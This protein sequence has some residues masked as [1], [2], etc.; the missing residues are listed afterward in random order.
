MYNCSN[1]HIVFVI[2]LDY[3][4]VRIYFYS[5]LTIQTGEHD[6]DAEKRK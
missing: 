1:V 6:G 4:D 5:I 2:S 3:C